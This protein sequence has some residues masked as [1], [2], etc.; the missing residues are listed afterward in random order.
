MEVDRHNGIPQKRALDIAEDANELNPRVAESK[1]DAKHAAA[2][3]AESNVF[4]NVN[5]LQKILML[6]GSN[7]MVRSTC[8]SFRKTQTVTETPI[9]D[10]V[11]ST[12][13]IAW[14]LEYKLPLLP[15]LIGYARHG[16]VTSVAGMLDKHEMRRGHLTK[17]AIEAALHGRVA[18]LHLF[19]ERGCDKR[20]ICSAA[21]GAGHLDALQLARANGCPW[22]VGTCEIAARNGHLAVLEWAH[23]NECPWNAGTCAAAAEGGHLAVLQYARDRNCPWLESTYNAAVKGGHLEV[24]RWVR[25]NGCD[26]TTTCDTAAK[27][28]DLKMLQKARDRGCHWNETTCAIAAA[29]GNLELLQWA[30]D[31][32]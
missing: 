9:A 12:A 19:L 23:V 5:L 3:D 14:S 31:E 10:A 20:K 22:S 15:A 1:R 25:D 29:N 27:K 30:H 13:L 8:V 32:G 6:A 4:D 16:D 18:V 11:L 2:L 26:T 7:I 17:G 24:L 21:A 28:G